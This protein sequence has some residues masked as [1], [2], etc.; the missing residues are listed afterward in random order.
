MSK[1][2][3]VLITGASSGIGQAIAQLLAQKDFSVFGTSRNPSGNGPFNITMLPLDVRSDESVKICIDAVIEQT[4]HLDILINNAGYVLAGAIEE[5][6][7][8]QAKNQFDTN[9]FWRDED[10]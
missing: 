5:I 7:L 8:E 2:R 9:F 6:T 3:T 1:Q 10:G 4:D